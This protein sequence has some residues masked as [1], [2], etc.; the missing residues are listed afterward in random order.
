MSHIE[1][2][3]HHASLI[4]SDTQQSLH[5]YANVLGMQQV[6]RPNLPFPGAWLK[7]GA[8]QQ[9]HLLELDNPDPTTG[10]PK[11]GGRDR[12]VALTVKDIAPVKDSLEKA[13]IAYTLSISGR[14][15]LFCRDPDGNAIEIIAEAELANMPAA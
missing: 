12:H 2:T 6:P 14:Q 13:N 4:V 1:Y 5:F 7:I 9:I 11:H 15:A 3:L 10:R 8:Q